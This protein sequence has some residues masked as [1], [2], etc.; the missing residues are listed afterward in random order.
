MATK[1]LICATCEETASNLS[2]TWVICGRCNETAFCS[3]ECLQNRSLGLKSHAKI[4]GISI[5]DT[6]SS[7]EREFFKTLVPLNFLSAPD[8]QQKDVF[9]LLGYCHFIWVADSFKCV[10]H[11][12]MGETF[13]DAAN[14]HDFRR[15]LDLAEKQLGVLPNW[16]SDQSRLECEENAMLQDL[17]VNVNNVENVI[18]QE[19]KDVLMPM[20][21]RLL[22]EKIYGTTAPLLL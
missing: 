14:M 7:S 21:L 13:E 11:V 20:K 1:S 8:F 17:E 18:I 10:P 16:W 4:C 9:E 15:F 12:H 3:L 5:L 19:H 6:M 22:G 2:R